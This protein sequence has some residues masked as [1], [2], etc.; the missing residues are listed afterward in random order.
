[1]FGLSFEIDGNNRITP[2]LQIF[3]HQRR[4]PQNLLV[5]FRLQDPSV[6]LVIKMVPVINVSFRTEA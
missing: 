2:I 3:R 5:P 1:M 4:P 6:L